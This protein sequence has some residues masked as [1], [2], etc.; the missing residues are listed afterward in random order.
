MELEN[1]ISEIIVFSLMFIFI[2]CVYFYNLSKQTNINLMDS[3]Y[4]I[5]WMILYFGNLLIFVIIDSIFYIYNPNMTLGIYIG[6][7]ASFI[8]MYNI[9]Q[10]EVKQR[11]IILK[12]EKPMPKT[13]S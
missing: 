5:K 11:N 9:G 6:I 13:K 2:N 8:Y 7:I 1:F 10:R 4:K 12:D 3:K